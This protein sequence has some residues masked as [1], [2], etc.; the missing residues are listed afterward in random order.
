MGKAHSP[1]RCGV[2]SGQV[3]EEV[4]VQC[5]ILNIQFNVKIAPFFRIRKPF[6]WRIGQG[7]YFFVLER[8]YFSKTSFFRATL[9]EGLCAW[10]HGGAM[11]PTAKAR[12]FSPFLKQ[13]LVNTAEGGNGWFSHHHIGCKS[14]HI[15]LYVHIEATL[16]RGFGWCY[17]KW[18]HQKWAQ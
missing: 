8:F 7:E 13:L 11:H 18:E 15:C 5:C 3:R 2:G 10:V 1:L 12:A 4:K 17:L 14:V 6:T 9:L 16:R